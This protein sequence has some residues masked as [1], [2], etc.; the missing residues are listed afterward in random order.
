[1]S[2]PDD[3]STQ[4]LPGAKPTKCPHRH[5]TEPTTERIK[6]SLSENTSVVVKGG[7]AVGVLCLCLWWF[8]QRI[9]KLEDTMARI[10]TKIDIMLPVKM[11]RNP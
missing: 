9:D 3:N 10:E 2:F 4:S 11:A 8:H 5:R 7:V 1:M 6:R